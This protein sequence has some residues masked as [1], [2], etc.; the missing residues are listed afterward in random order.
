MAKGV[1][2][3][4]ANIEKVVIGF[5]VVRS[6][7]DKSTSRRGTLFM[8]FATFLQT[9]TEERC[10]IVNRFANIAQMFIMTAMLSMQFGSP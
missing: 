10:G 6:F 2:Q 1:F 8:Y 5:F 7:C 4:S 9:T 3:E